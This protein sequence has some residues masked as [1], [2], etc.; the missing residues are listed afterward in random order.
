MLCER[1]RNRVAGYSFEAHNKLASCSRLR[2]MRPFPA[3]ALPA[4]VSCPS[5]SDM[6]SPGAPSPGPPSTTTS[7]INLAQRSS[8]L[9]RSLEQVTTTYKTE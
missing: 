9:Q 4:Q 7:L 3:R 6:S 2:L 1:P 8:E 5:P